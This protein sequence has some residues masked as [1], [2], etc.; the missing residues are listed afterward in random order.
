MIALTAAYLAITYAAAPAV[1]PTHFD[2]AGTPNAFARKTIGS[3]F[4]LVWAQL[5]LEILITALAVLAVR[6]KA[7]PGRAERRFRRRTLRFLFFIKALTLAFLGIVAVLVAQTSLTAHPRLGPS[8]ALSAVFVLLTLGAAFAL[9]ITTGQGGARLGPAEETATDRLDDRY[10]KLGAIYVNRG[11]PSLFVE[12]RF[13]IGW[14]FNLGNPRAIG[15][16]VGIVAIT[17]LFVVVSIVVT[18]PR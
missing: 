11:D 2:L 13:G 15:V 4:G 18:A 14:T 17:A 5:F 8:L 6:A 10:W 7:V 1:I 16:L 12:R 3:Y 9:G